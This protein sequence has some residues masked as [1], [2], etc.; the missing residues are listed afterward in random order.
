MNFKKIS[1]LVFLS[2]VFPG[3]KIHSA[4][5]EE[6]AYRSDQGN[7]RNFER[8]S[9]DNDPRKQSRT[10][11][12]EVIALF[13]SLSYRPL[14][15]GFELLGL[16]YVDFLET[17]RYL[18]PEDGDANMDANDIDFMHK[19]VVAAENM[20]IHKMQV[21]EL[22]EG[23]EQALHNNT[24]LDAANQR[25]LNYALQY[26]NSIGGSILQAFSVYVDSNKMLISAIKR[27]NSEIVQRLIDAG[28]DLNK[29]HYNDE[30][31][32]G[33]INV[34]NNQ[35]PLGR[36]VIQGN[37]KIIKKLIAAGAILDIVDYNGCPALYKAI[38]KGKIE[39][40]QILI[41]AG[42]SV[43]IIDNK[44]WSS[45]HYAVFYGRNDDKISDQI[46]K[47]LIAAG[48]HL[49]IVD[50]HGESPL[51]LAVQFK[52]NKI[53]TILIE[54]GADI[55]LMGYKGETPLS[56]ASPAIR[57]VMLQAVKKRESDN[58]KRES[59]QQYLD[60]LRDEKCTIC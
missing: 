17:Q 7:K 22:I 55:N 25:I 18:I 60:H 40:I 29:F 45:L 44:G 13:K 5:G 46:A 8:G 53:V 24:D 50:F 36:A 30:F 26:K 19:I 28:I 21:V 43:N 35:S 37:K 11:Q 39:I 2:M 52:K 41:A 4:A 54:A 3:A 14:Q 31:I 47:N 57:N 15:E 6:G 56:I 59:G 58:R 12:D 10:F 48:A 32:P 1:L 9:E 42:A 16:D 23:F 38:M 49:N 20:I 51:Y 34:H 33:M 27:D